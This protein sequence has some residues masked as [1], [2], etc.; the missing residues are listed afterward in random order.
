[1][2]AIALATASTFVS[3][4]DY[5]DDITNLQEQIDANSDALKAT[6]TALEAEITN[7]KSQLDATKTELTGLINKAQAAA[8][9]AQASAD[10]AQAAADKAQA[11]ADK[12]A[13][14][15]AD[16]AARAKAAE[17]AN[18]DA[19]NAEVL[20]A[21]AKEAALEAR[22]EAAEK[23]LEDLKA[24][25]NT[26]VDQTEFDAAVKDIY[27]KIA[28]VDE[29]VAA[30]LK[31]IEALQKGLD[32]E[33]VARK[34][35]AADLEEQKS[36]LNKLTD[37][38]TKLEG[39]VKGINEEIAKIKENVAKAQ[40][41]IEALQ[42]AV[43]DNAKSI[44]E[45]KEDIKALDARLTTA[46]TTADTALQ[47]A[48]KAL[49]AAA[50]NK[51]AIE[52]EA[53]RAKEAEAEAKAAA[54]A[55]QKT[56]DQAVKDAAN[57]QKTADQAVKDAANAKAAADKAQAAAEKA[58]ATADKNA[59][60]LAD[61]ATRAKAAE[62]KAQAA[63]E[64]A[65]AAAE[66]AQATANTA[67]ANAKTAQDTAD[68]AQKYAEKVESELTA[69]LE[70][71]E[72]AIKAAQ[73][74]ADAAKAA[75][76]KAQESA[77]AAQTAADKAQA[78]A[79]QA[80][81]EINVLTVYV[82]HALRSLVLDPDE[83]YWGVEAVNI[84]A[85][86]Y[87]PMTLEAADLSK[88]QQDDAPEV[89]QSE[90]TG[91]NAFFEANYFLNPSGANVSENAADY[92]FVNVKDVNYTRVAACGELKVVDVKKGEGKINVQGTVQNPELI[93]EILMNNMVTVFALQ[94]N[95]E[96]SVITSDFAALRRSWMK[97]FKLN[98]VETEGAVNVE[99][100]HNHLYTTAADAVENTPV[101]KLTYNDTKGIDL[102]E[103]INAH[104]NS[105]NS[106][107]GDAL[108]GGQEKVNKAGFAIQYELIGYDKTGKTN[109]SKYAKIDG[110]VIKAQNPAGG[111]PVVEMIGH[112]PLV[113]VKLVNTQDNNTVVAVGY[114]KVAI[115]GEATNINI[116]L[117]VDVDL[118]CGDEVVIDTCVLDNKLVEE[119]LMSV[120]AF[121]TFELVMD[122]QTAE[123]TQ[124]N[125]KGETT[126]AWGV[127][128]GNACNGKYLNLQVK[129]GEA[130]AAFSKNV[131]KS[132]T[133]QYT[134]EELG[135]DIYVTIN[136]TNKKL[137]EAPVINIVDADKV[138]TTW[139]A[140]NSKEN[141]Y[142]EIHAHVNEGTLEASEW[143]FGLD[144][145]NWKKGASVAK[146]E[147][148]LKAK[149]SLDITGITYKF[150]EPTVKEV[151]MASYPGQ[152]A[153]LSV[154][155][156][157]SQL[158]A[159]FGQAK[160]T[161][162]VLDT[163]TGVVTYMNYEDSPLA[164]EVLNYAAHNEL[165]DGE[166][167]T[168][169]VGIN[170]S[171]CE[172]IGALKSTGNEFDIKFL[173][174]ISFNNENATIIDSNPSTYTQAVTVNFWDW[175]DWTPEVF[176]ENTGKDFAVFYGLKSIKQN[177]DAKVK[178]NFGDG[179][180]FVELGAPL[181]DY[182]KFTLEDVEEITLNEDGTLTVNVSY[183]KLS[184]VTVH[185]FQAQI[186]VVLEYTWGKLNSYITVTVQPTVENAKVARK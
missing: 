81:A 102:D 36:A 139:F 14:D 3:C 112:T 67:V 167:L 161:I 101:F 35:L 123:A 122:P 152:K 113:R 99:T 186:P 125:E 44:E 148:V 159:T 46:Q 133:V 163:I 13:K 25:V 64:K 110:S 24:L 10:K 114:F 147:D 95:V 22:I 42:K 19:I 183:E 132:V 173:R 140:H 83:Y 109:E 108:W 160:Q 53:K 6:K 168:A 73:D 56:A 165:N 21:T 72:A 89:G 127:V 170:T 12:N 61:E 49:E 66:K 118:A 40:K 124:F 134:N 117:D 150:V 47:A 136:L 116:D 135:Q 88:D 141:G 97:N 166:T 1:M 48:N 31:S 77:N 5:D 129:N 80:I 179:K 93:K 33:I 137:L 57:A 184:S 50:A 32:D 70:E 55:A 30:N 172:P 104:F 87:F 65:Q 37:R 174:P 153:K 143:T 169:R 175:R 74:A 181:T 145:A 120:E 177:T 158:V 115:I 59:K 144:D 69:R 138:A 180:T 8:D 121:Q 155:D 185:T 119:K 146:L 62:A 106:Y 45:I 17:K 96:D 157:G 11:T 78:T 38:V 85:Y 79:N 162:A 18:A 82:H 58:Q 100:A 107:W 29:K 39:D 182:F 142:A 71:A 103:W 54:Q 76:D 52:N 4:K 149:V 98:K 63:A 43:A 7:L 23:A 128:S 60:D 171:V 34:A 130:Y 9:A 111:E 41:D 26:K 75:A 2:G 178:T 126:A 27:A 15:L 151:G 92:N 105:N 164:G 91:K 156:N 84:K 86:A 28:A 176:A 94:Y 16:E 68:A 131:K 20:R 154:E 90:V 51:L